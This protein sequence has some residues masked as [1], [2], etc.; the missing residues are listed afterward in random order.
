MSSRWFER[1]EHR[2]EPIRHEPYLNR[3]NAL[4]GRR[5]EFLQ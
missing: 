4:F 5:I 1:S 2:R 3:S